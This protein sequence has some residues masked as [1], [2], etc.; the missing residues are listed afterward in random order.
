VE[1]GLKVKRLEEELA[2]KDERYALLLAKMSN[3]E[4]EQQK[5]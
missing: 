2:V 1:N 5:Q 4:A 3:G